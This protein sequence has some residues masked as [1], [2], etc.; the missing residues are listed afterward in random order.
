M[1]WDQVQRPKLL[2]RTVSEA[3]ARG[4]LLSMG[5]E[6]GETTMRHQNVATRTT[7]D[8]MHSRQ[9]TKNHNDVIP[10]GGYRTFHSAATSQE[11]RFEGLNPSSAAPRITKFNAKEVVCIHHK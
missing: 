10:V 2:R 5:K 8:V 3:V 4:A 7:K 11:Q 6:S 9:S 1:F